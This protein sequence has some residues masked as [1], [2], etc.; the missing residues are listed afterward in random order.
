[1]IAMRDCATTLLL[2]EGDPIPA[3]IWSGVLILV[4]I[5]LFFLIG[6]YRRWMAS[7][8]APGGVGFTLSDLRRFH[9]EGKMTTEEFEK[10]KLI[11]LG[12]LKAS[13]DKPVL[14]PRTP[15]PPADAEPGQN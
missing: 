9:K 7:S 11:L 2:A 6:R 15:R 1:L 3:I 14:G 8:D 13:A 12:P 4:L 10:A 5:V